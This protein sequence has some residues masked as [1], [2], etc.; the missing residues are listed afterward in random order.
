M[1]DKVSTMFTFSDHPHVSPIATFLSHSKPTAILLTDRQQARIFTVNMG[2]VREWTDFQDCVPSRSAVGGWSQMRY[3]RRSDNWVRQHIDHATELTLK[4][5]QHYPF[6]WL[7]LGSDVDAEHDLKADLHPYLKDRVIGEIHVRI[8]A[9]AAEV[10]E[11]AR[12]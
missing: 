5:L 11:K 1:P 7:I 8:D 2:E 6:D 10:L 9:D 4:L 12:V 3:Q